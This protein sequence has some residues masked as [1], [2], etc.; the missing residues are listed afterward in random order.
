[1]RPRR[2]AG[3]ALCLLALAAA[4]PARAMPHNGDAPVGRWLT[5]DRDAVIDIESCG[6][7]LCGRIVGI[8]LDRPQDPI[9][10][11]HAG[12]SQCGLDIIQGVVPADGG[13]WSARIV[14]PRDGSIYSA[15]LHLDPEHRLHLRGYIGI[16]L[17][18]RTQ[19]WTPFERSVPENCRLPAL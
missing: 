8:T 6:D 13:A 2:R 15:R 3:M 14:D 17:F 10:T 19:V 4:L 16:P 9:P 12:R 11:D 18:G 7:A 1:M 5:E